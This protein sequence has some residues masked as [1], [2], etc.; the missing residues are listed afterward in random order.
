MVPR[1]SILICCFTLAQALTL[2]KPDVALAKDMETQEDIHLSVAALRA[3]VD[4]LNKLSV[5]SHSL[6]DITAT[7]SL[8][9]MMRYMQ[10]MFK[11][12]HFVDTL[13]R[14][15][16]G[17]GTRIAKTGHSVQE[18]ADKLNRQSKSLSQEEVMPLLK[19]FFERQDMRLTDTR[20]DVMATTSE[21]LESIPQAV[22]DRIKAELDYAD[23]SMSEP[24]DD[25]ATEYA[26]LSK[27]AG[28][29]DPVEFC[30]EFN[31]AKEA[32]NRRRT[33]YEPAIEE[34]GRA[35]EALP[36]IVMALAEQESFPK[37]LSAAQKF[38]DA[39]KATYSSLDL[40]A[41]QTINVIGNIADKKLKCKN[42]PADPQP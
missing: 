11:D 30:K 32:L 15:G 27:L 42:V 6:M 8:K 26:E 22:R 1:A 35:R 25:A 19:D 24:F 13:A 23:A 5:L 34:M 37:A 16:D 9:Q 10:E 4:N 40:S 41:Q 38:I 2:E 18:A 29:M 14:I 21:L 28:G 20:V 36:T 33:F 31:Q 12:P 7:V 39:V 3:A 17:F